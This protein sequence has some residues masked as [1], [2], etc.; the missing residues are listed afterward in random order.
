MQ[1]LKT[2]YL[3]AS[4]SIIILSFNTAIAQNE[5]LGLVSSATPE[6]TESGAQILKKGGNAVDA[7]VAIAF[8][9][10]VTEPAMSGIGGR[11]M[12]I[13]SLPN[14]EPMAIGGV[15]LT[16]AILDSHIEKKDL[17]FYKQVSIPSQ[18]KILNY[19][20]KK[21]GSGQLKWEELLEPAIHYAENGFVNGVHRHHVFKRVQQKFLDNPYHNRELLVDNEIPA[22]GDVI[23]QPTLARTL[24]QLAE[25]GGDD[26]Y[27]GNIAK[28]I[29]EDFKNH[30]GWITYT[31][32]SNFPEP[33]E[34]KPLHINYRGYDIYSFVP[35]GG[36]WQVLQVL[37]LLEHYNVNDLKANTNKRTLAILNVLNISHNDRLDNAIKDYDNFKSE[38]DE[39]ISK[40]YAKTL[41]ENI[42]NTLNVNQQSEEKGQGETTHFSVTDR[43]GIAVS[44]T[45]SVGAYFGSITS[46]KNLGF[47]Y[48]SYLKSLMGFGLGKS[49]EPNV[50][51]PSSMSPSLIKKDGKNVL[52]I[53]TPGSKRIVS[54]ISQLIQLWVDS[55]MSIT[56]IIKEPRVH[57][58]RNLA[59]IEDEKIT[60]KSLQEVRSKGFKI[61][62]PDYDLTNAS[63]LNAYFGGVHAI[64]YKNHQWK[65]ASDPR[66]DGTTITVTNE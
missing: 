8:T 19:V 54:T 38:I 30:G 26:F 6:A 61:T 12:I 43:E 25:N 35:P 48:N 1:S 10:G 32:L 39:K 45:S 18:V 34:Y 42:N 51:I 5:P 24:K 66:R 49:L 14:Q 33:K 20:W 23:K 3:I 40:K 59:Y 60:S 65:A 29:A 22:I 7:A 17:T 57:A 47:F 9:L 63:G 27:K 55:E 31:D 41:L 37:N 56:D 58:I 15:S 36:G 46:T 16:P 64:E 52:V 13:L 21:Y 2:M 53:G 62:F 4:V 28:E 44:V 50:N 11:T